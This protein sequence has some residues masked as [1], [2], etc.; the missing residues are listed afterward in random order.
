[1]IAFQ[2]DNAGPWVLHCHIAWHASAGLAFQAL[3]EVEEFKDRLKYGTPE[4]QKVQ[5]N[6]TC[7]NWKD[8]Q[9]ERKNHFYPT[10]R[11]QDDSGI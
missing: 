4:W 5:L 11:F 7:K 6:E 2:T 1:M 9:D 3:E 10:G 8:W